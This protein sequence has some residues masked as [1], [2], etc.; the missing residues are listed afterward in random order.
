MTLWDTDE[1]SLMSA[2]LLEPQLIIFFPQVFTDIDVIWLF[3]S[4]ALPNHH[5]RTQA[6]N[7]LELAVLQIHLVNRLVLF[8]GQALTLDRCGCLMIQID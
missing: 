6:V 4:A 7:P 1:T 8:S 2:S 3:S 5:N